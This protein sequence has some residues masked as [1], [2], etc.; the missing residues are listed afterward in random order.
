MFLHFDTEPENLAVIDYFQIMKD[1]NSVINECAAMSVKF[2]VL[3]KTNK[4]NQ[5]A[6][7][8]KTIALVMYM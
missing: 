8:L 2:L 7:N 3:I 1:C 5:R 6:Y 4:V